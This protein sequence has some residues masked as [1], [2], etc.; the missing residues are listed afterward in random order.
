MRNSQ[1]HHV[2]IVIGSQML[3]PP[4]TM[5]LGIDIEIS[6]KLPQKNQPLQSRLARITNIPRAMAFASHF[7]FPPFQS[8]EDASI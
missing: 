3:P 1:P 2:T 8:H 7:S 4:N 6:A 5:T